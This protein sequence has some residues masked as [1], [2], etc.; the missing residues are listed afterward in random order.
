MNNFTLMAPANQT[1]SELFSNG[2]KYIIPRFQRDYA[3]DQE[4]WEDLWQDIETLEEEGYHYMGY[5]VLQK[6][7]EYEF[8]VIDGQQ[9]LVTFSFVA[10]AAM[11]KIQAF[12]DAGVEVDD[13]NERLRVLKERL[14]GS[15]NPVTLKVEN[16]LSLN[17]NNHR[18]F[19]EICSKMRV[20]KERGV[21]RTNTLL[22]GAFNFFAKKIIGENGSEIAQ[23]IERVASRM[24]FTKIVTQDNINA[25]KV[26]ETL[27]ARG[28]QLSTPDLLKNHIFSTLTA[29]NDIADE[30]LD[31]LDEDWATII[32]QLGESNFTD[33]VRY[34]H[35]IQKALI[36]KKGLFKSVKQIV[37]TPPTA[38]RYLESLKDY[39]PVYAALLRPND[40]WWK[41][42]GN[43]RKE[44]VHYLE[45]LKLFQIKQPFSALMAASLDKFTEE[46]FIKTLKYLY[47][48]SVRYNVICR[49]SPNEQEKA[50]NK[51][52]MKI[53]SGD[54]SRASHIKNSEEFRHL[55]PDDQAF[56]NAFEFYKMPSRRSSKKIRFLLTE[57]ENSFGR[58]LSYLDTSLEHVCPY[59]PNQAWCEEFGEGINDIVDRLGNMVLLEKDDL[60][61]VDFATKKQTYLNTA[62]RLAKK[63]A[64]ADSWDIAT[65]NHYQSWL[66]DQAVK[67]WRVDYQ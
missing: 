33:F 20:L 60:G 61:R 42:W 30:T 22:D 43:F 39:A 32:A 36:T 53:F 7:G 21:S 59:N 9:R 4:Q 6:K 11:R 5:I 46:E 56:R 31:I 10:L 65:L 62:F 17:R 8:E 55:Y 44:I 35:N 40:E 41:G 63:V 38:S 28:V 49:F 64:E 25:Y 12:I 45:G 48:L 29:N 19:R 26:F 50:Y 54:L 23:F 58:E 2:V 15:T 67:T 3:W 24:V 13:N 52:A 57:I 34:H 18:Y 66:A 37:S 27:N 47:I 1:F 14:I 51:I 16:K